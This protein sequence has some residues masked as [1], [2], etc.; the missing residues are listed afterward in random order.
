MYPRV[1]TSLLYQAGIPSYC[2]QVDIPPTVQN[3]LLPRLWA[4]E[5]THSA[6]ECWCPSVQKE[7]Q[8]GL[9]PDRK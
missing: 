8:T 1:Y 7:V 5:S 6:Q 4:Q 3:W 9:K 2:T